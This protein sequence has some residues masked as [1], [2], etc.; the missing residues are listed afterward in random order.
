MDQS[1]ASQD[2]GV[3][4]RK[5][6]IKLLKIFYGVTNDLQTQ[7]DICARLI[8]RMVDEDDSVK[9][10]EIQLRRWSGS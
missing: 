4:V 10:K 1:D 5:R 2:T 8:I 3:G 9:V 7:V 6:V